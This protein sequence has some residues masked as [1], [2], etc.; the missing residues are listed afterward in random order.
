MHL[1]IYRFI[2]LLPHRS[3]DLSGS[4]L[5]SL[6]TVYCLWC[7]LYPRLRA[8]KNIVA[9]FVGLLTFEQ[10]RIRVLMRAVSE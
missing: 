2:R 5:P 8:L 4:S 3:Q 7:G 6:P 1:S 9:Y 10:S